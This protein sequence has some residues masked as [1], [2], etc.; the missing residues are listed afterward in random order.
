MIEPRVV[1]EP[2][3]EPVTLIEVRNQCHIDSTIEDS[4]LEIFI[5]D[6]RRNLEKWTG[7]TFH[8]TEYLWTI[9]EWPSCNY[10]RLPYATPLISITSLKYLDQNGVETTWAASNYIA[11]T[12]SQIGRLVLAYGASWPSTTLYPVAPIRIQYVAGIATTSPIT[13]A[14][15]DVKEAMLL[16][17]AGMNENRESEVITDRTAVKVT[18]LH[19]GVQSKI[20]LLTVDRRF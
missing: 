9:N 18:D 5:G 4:T 15:D 16:L 11:D 17:V 14:T 2:L 10:I 13:E 8:Q 12:F 19:Y 3:S 6:A 7:R 1:T 20:E